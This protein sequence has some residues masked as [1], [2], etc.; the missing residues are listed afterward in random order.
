[1]QR[2]DLRI[3]IGRT[4]RLGQP[5]DRK[6]GVSLVLIARSRGAIQSGQVVGVIVYCHEAVDIAADPCDTD[7]ERAVRCHLAP[8]TGVRLFG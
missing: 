2:S 1:M 3:G 4:G 5:D 7:A 6:R 8:L